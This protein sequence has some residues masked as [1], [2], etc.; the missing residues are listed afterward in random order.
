[1]RNIMERNK[2]EPKE[3]KINFEKL[4][5][6]IEKSPLTIDEA[7]ML[8]DLYQSYLYGWM[9][10][11]DVQLQDEMYDKAEELKKNLKQIQ[12]KQ[13]ILRPE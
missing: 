5:R 9:K 2:G 10:G 6:I 8:I 1:M 3:W 11:Y 13:I 12:S 7:E 4:K